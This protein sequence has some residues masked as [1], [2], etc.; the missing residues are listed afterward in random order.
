MWHV[1]VAG[2]VLR[3]TVEHP[4]WV[5]N[6]QSWLSVGELRVGDALRTDSGELLP[7]E[8]IEDSG[9][10]EKV[11]N[12][13]IEDYHTYFVASEE[14]GLAFWAHNLDCAGHARILRGRLIAA[15]KKPLTYAAHLIPTG[16]WSNRRKPIRQIIA[17]LQ[18]M[19]NGAGIDIDDAVNGFFTKS[20]RHL[21][22]HTND[23]FL[24]LWDKLGHLAGNR[25]EIISA[26]G[27]IAQN[28]KL[29]RL[30]FK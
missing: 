12:W 7:V 24:H 28:L 10:W 20:R 22:T 16:A 15:G 29:G 17:N 9:K 1:R 21:G 6:R 14:W 30:R 3:A 25:D 23:F 13:E 11:Y 4:F 19:L 26:L 8:A 5:E 27:E 2:Q 18:T